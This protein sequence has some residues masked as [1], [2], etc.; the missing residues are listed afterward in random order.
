MGGQGEMLRSRR[1]SS[2]WMLLAFHLCTH[3]AQV[4][5]R[6][7]A[8]GSPM[9]GQCPLAACTCIG[10]RR[11]HHCRIAWIAAAA[12]AAAAVVVLQCKLLCVVF[13]CRRSLCCC[14]STP[15]F[16]KLNR[17]VVHEHKP[18]TCRPP[19]KSFFSTV[20]ELVSPSLACV[21]CAAAVQKCDIF[22]NT[23]LTHASLLVFLCGV[24]YRCSRMISARDQTNEL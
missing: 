13:C 4:S 8:S 3:Q 9:R 15:C 23:H 6:V 24:W 11:L 16:I 19:K 10:C 18:I 12:A 21:A 14:S 20:V 22:C 2:M 7:T 17:F 5:C 1:L